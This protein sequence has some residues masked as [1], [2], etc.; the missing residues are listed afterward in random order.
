MYVIADIMSFVWGSIVGN[1]ILWCVVYGWSELLWCG[2]GVK[3]RGMR[4][5]SKYQFKRKIVNHL[6]LTS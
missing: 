3:L 2:G 4:V 5:I 6:I 1:E